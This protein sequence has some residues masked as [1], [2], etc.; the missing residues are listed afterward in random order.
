MAGLTN[1]H[2]ILGA[3]RPSVRQG[4]F[5]YV[6]LPTPPEVEAYARIVEDEGITLVVDQSTAD[7]HGWEYEG[8]FAWITLQVHT[9]LTSV[10]IT[11]AVSTALARVG[12]SCNVLAGYYHDHLLVPAESV[13]EAIDVLGGLES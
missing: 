10:G 6:T 2:E 11:A 4:S 5:V 8:V 1:L 3:L 13:D 12:I 9:S 7:E